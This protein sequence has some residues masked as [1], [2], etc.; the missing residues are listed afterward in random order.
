[1]VTGYEIAYARSPAHLKAL[2][3]AIFLSQ[4]ALSSALGLMIS[5][6][7]RDPN[8]IFVWAGPAIALFLQTLIF[9]W[10]YRWLNNDAFMTIDRDKAASRQE[11]IAE[12]TCSLGTLGHSPDVEEKDRQ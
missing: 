9:Y 12:R 10:R 2:V 3:V 4:K 6:A 8:L 7:I 5:P 1:M 11:S